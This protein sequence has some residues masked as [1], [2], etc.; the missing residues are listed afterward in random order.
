MLAI[1]LE[2][3]RKEYRNKRGIHG[4]TFQVKQGEIFGYLGPNGAGK[5]TT[6]RTLL[7]LLTPDAGKARIMG[8]DIVTDNMAVC[9]ITGYLPGENALYNYLSGEDNL[10]FSLYVRGRPDCLARG[11]QIADSLGVDLRAKLRHLSH[12]QRQ[13]VAIVVALAHDPDVLILDEPTSGLDPLVQETIFELIRAEQSAGKTVFM[14]SHILSEV[15]ALCGRVAI[16]RQGNLVEV[17]E[18]EA[19]R[20]NKVKRVTLIYNQ[21]PPDVTTWPGV[22]ELSVETGQVRFAYQ[23]D[24]KILLQHLAEQD[25]A[26]VVITDPSLE[27]VFRTFY[28]EQEQV[29]N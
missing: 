7:G 5:S 28:R 21:T 6:I 3:L 1:E 13:K 2:N 29:V 18:V 15:E 11:R 24:V 22:S 26:D 9:K 20:R 4:L 12:G 14:S 16:I 27:E 19:L 10:R 17:N 23:G 25:I 8:H